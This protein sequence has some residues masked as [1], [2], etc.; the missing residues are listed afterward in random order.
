MIE[1]IVVLVQ[2]WSK[3]AE[4]E[5]ERVSVAE[6]AKFVMWSSALPHV[7]TFN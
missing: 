6:S 2:P 1:A 5:G 3:S 7:R 4:S